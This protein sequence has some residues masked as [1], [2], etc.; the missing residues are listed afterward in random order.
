MTLEKSSPVFTS[1]VPLLQS[2]RMRA[3]GLGKDFKENPNLRDNWTDAEGYYRE[4]S[5][6]QSSVIELIAG[7]SSKKEF[8]HLTLLMRVLASPPREGHG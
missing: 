8:I 4:F 1:F 7:H 6:P 5:L 2:A 3:A